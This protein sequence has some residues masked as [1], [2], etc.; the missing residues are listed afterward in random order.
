MPIENEIKDLKWLISDLE[1]N[2]SEIEKLPI[3]HEKDWFLI[4]AVEMNIIRDTDTQLIWGALSGIPNN[5]EIEPEQIELPFAEGNEQIWKNGNLQVVNSKIE[6]IAW[7]SSYTIVKF[8][9]NE[10]SDKFKAYFQEAIE[11]ENYKWKE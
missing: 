4:S 7:D 2:T 11:L 5:Q 3:N 10:M 6:I 9:D 8:T 1:I